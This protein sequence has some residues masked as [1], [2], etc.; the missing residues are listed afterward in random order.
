VESFLCFKFRNPFRLEDYIMVSLKAPGF[1]SSVPGAYKNICFLILMTL[2]LL[3]PS[4]CSFSDDDKPKA[5]TEAQPT[6][7]KTADAPKDLPPPGPSGQRLFEKN[8]RDEDARLK[9]LEEAVQA[10]RDEFDAI[11]PS[12]NRLMGVEADIQKIVSQLSTLVQNE[13]AAPLNQDIQVNQLNND[14]GAIN[15]ALGTDDRNFRG[16]QPGEQ[17]SL[18]P[19]APPVVATDQPLRIAPPPPPMAAPGPVAKAPPPHIPPPPRAAPLEPT[20]NIP[21]PVPQTSNP[22]PSGQPQLALIRMADSAGKTRIVM[23][24]AGSMTYTSDLDNR[25]NILTLIFPQGTC[26]DVGTLAFHSGLVKS[27][28]Q[29][30]QDSNGFILAFILNRA[31]K[32]IDQGV[33]PPN[34]DNPRYRIWIDLAK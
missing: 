11:K 2:A 4:G 15:H 16:P 10:M 34:A 12:V 33:I 25:E 28:T 17:Q 31:T 22:P 23:E 1:S 9:R 3:G 29:T 19:S 14:Q 8:L 24:A 26:V 18:T 7:L 20:D 5:G 13:G 21:P 32:I 30:P 27:V 6:E